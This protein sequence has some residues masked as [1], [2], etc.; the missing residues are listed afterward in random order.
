MMFR[1]LSLECGQVV[2]EAR[3]EAGSTSLD[4]GLSAAADFQLMIRIR[5]SGVTVRFPSPAGV[6]QERGVS[7]FDTKQIG[8]DR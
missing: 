1:R 8:S 6:A 2:I 5:P 3:K 4:R 7:L